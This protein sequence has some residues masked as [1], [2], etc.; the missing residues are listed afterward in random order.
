MGFYR[1]HFVPDPARGA[2]KESQLNRIRH[3]KA[4]KNIAGKGTSRYD[5]TGKNCKCSTQN[6]NDDTEKH[7][8]SS[9][10][11]TKLKDTSDQARQM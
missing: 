7:G 6:V 5:I 8:H 3:I 1:H 11:T 10:H 9:K 4:N 2:A